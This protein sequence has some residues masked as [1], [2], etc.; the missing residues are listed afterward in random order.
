MGDTNEWRWFIS[1]Q[2][3]DL[4]MYMGHI[5]YPYVHRCPPTPTSA[6]VEAW[7]IGGPENDRN[8]CWTGWLWYWDELQFLFLAW[9]CAAWMLNIRQEKS[10][11]WR[12]LY[13]KLRSAPRWMKVSYIAISAATWL[14]IRLE[15]SS[16]IYPFGITRV[17]CPC[18]VF[19]VTGL[20]YAWIDIIIPKEI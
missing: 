16:Q 4:Q 19:P 7:R 1:G 11:I 17:F 9:R 12:F 2:M 6:T 5:L 8:F 3:W 20:Q 18:S 15:I 13:H 14:S 10:V